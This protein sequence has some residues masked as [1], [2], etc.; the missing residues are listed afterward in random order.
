MRNT[1]AT[2]LSEALKELSA[3]GIQFGIAEKSSYGSRERT[4]RMRKQAE[5][6]LR[7]AARKYQKVFDSVRRRFKP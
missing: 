3:A 6:R 5:D 2:K 7:T 4:S 1:L